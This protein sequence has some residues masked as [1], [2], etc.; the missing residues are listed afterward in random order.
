MVQS[1][2]RKEIRLKRNQHILD[3]VKIN[4]MTV[5][6]I[7]TIKLLGKTLDKK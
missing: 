7:A 5:S 1:T 2:M 4:K 3:D 6:N